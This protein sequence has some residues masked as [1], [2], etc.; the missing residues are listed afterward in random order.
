MQPYAHAVCTYIY[1]LYLYLFYI[2]LDISYVKRK[3]IAV[4]APLF[5]EEKIIGVQT[6]WTT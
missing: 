3:K 4:K 5:D 2:F 1:K 6:T